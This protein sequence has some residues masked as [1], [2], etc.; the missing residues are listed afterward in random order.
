M[1]K[2]WNSEACAL[3]TD[4]SRDLDGGKKLR[5]RCLRKFNVAGSDRA[6]VTILAC[7]RASRTIHKSH[8]AN[9]AL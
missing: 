4:L 5:E 3:T 1:L 2:A 6:V 9:D 7:E 8:L